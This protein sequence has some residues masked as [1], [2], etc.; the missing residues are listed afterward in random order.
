MKLGR[1]QQCHCGSGKKYKKC[2]LEK[3]EK[4]ERL[5]QRV[6]NID[7][8]N[9]FISG[10]YKKC[11]NT[12]CQS[13][14]SFGVFMP[15]EGA[16]SYSRKCKVCKHEAAFPLPEIKKKILYLDQFV[17]SN[18]IKLL[19]KD[20]PSHSTIKTDPF[21]EKLFVKLEK[22]SKSQAIVCPDSFYHRD[23]SLTGSID[24]RLMKRLYEHFSSGKTLYPSLV[25]EKF[26]IIEHFKSWLEGKK[27]KFELDP[28]HISFGSDL[29]TWSVGM[30]VSVGG[31]PYPGQIESLQKTNATTKNDLGEIWKRWQE[32]K[33]VKF[34]NRVK[35]EALGLGKGLAQA[36]QQF[37]VRR[38]NAMARVAA[39]ENYEMELD[40]FMP[41]M[42]N[43][44]VESIVS[45]CRSKK[46]DETQIPVTV[47]KYFN[48]VNALLE[49]PVVRISSVI[50]A[51]WAHRAAMGKK[52]PPK[53]TA[54]VQFISSYLPYCDAL[55]VDKESAQLLREFPKNT[56]EYL[57]I[58]EFPAKI[59]SLRNKDD[60]LN[61]LDEVVAEIP[62]E[63]MEILKDVSGDSYNNPYW[64]IIE[65]EKRELR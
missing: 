6:M 2:C 20:H 3:D 9:L 15:I 63:Q 46:I 47:A 11:P 31:N 48:D 57:R 10:P 4:S 39:G 27:H 40:D 51:G 52:E 62:A 41:P 25:V 60:F 23:E 58:Q 26:Q 17:I 29:H 14:N 59:F 28:Q 8:Q 49:V 30:R 38:N 65:N 56:P 61:Y 18:L 12:T 24:F 50:F 54:D 37:V 42:S 44:V 19:D 7:F 16:S 35:E 34:E 1:N 5:K 53:S 32:E 21:W 45:I 33:H 55:F 43:E 64:E 36:A 22:A 13:E